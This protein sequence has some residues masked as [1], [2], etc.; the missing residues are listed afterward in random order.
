MDKFAP[1]EFWQAAIPDANCEYWARMPHWTEEEAAALLLGVNPEIMTNGSDSWEDI[2]RAHAGQYAGILALTRRVTANRQIEPPCTPARWLAWA[3][4]LD[5][6][7]PEE[8]RQ[9]VDQW[10]GVGKASEDR[11]AESLLRTRI[12]ELEAELAA[13]Q[14]AHREFVQGL[15]AD[16]L[17]ELIAAAKSNQPLG[18]RER[19]TMLKIVIGMAVKGY[20]FD[21][22]ASRS[23]RINEIVRDVEKCG[24]SVSDDT[25]RR[26]LKEAAEL[27]PAQRN[28]EL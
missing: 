7:V 27:L 5:M 12:E 6:P 21:P 15:K 14:N 13:V 3:I 4:A 19:E 1:R 24:L 8:L 2:V 23:D 22:R 25:V 10:D 16:H 18:A 28:R 26:Y 17:A 11:E 20:S 9:L